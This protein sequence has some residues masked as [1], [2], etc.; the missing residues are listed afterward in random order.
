MMR[1]LEMINQSHIEGTFIKQINK[2]E[3]IDLL[4]LYDFGLQ[5]INAR[6]RIAILHALEDVMQANLLSLPPSYRLPIGILL[7]TNQP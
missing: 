4:I 1:F 7:L 5:A 3:K 2:I 6:Q